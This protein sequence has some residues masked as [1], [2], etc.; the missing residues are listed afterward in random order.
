LTFSE[1]CKLFFIGEGA[2]KLF[3][4]LHL[5]KTMNKLNLSLFLSFA[6]I[7]IYLNGQ[8][9]LQVNPICGVRIL[10]RNLPEVGLGGKIKWITAPVV[11]IEIR[12]KERPLS[13]SFQKDWYLDISPYSSPEATLAFNYSLVQYWTENNFLVNYDFGK[14]WQVNLGY[15]DMFRENNL[16]LFSKLYTRKWSGILYGL[17]KKTDWFSIGLRSKV[18]LN[19]D[20]AFLVGD[21]LYSL[22]MTTNFKSNYA[23][24]LNKQFAFEKNIV[25]KATAGTRIFHP[26]GDTLLVNEA[27]PKVGFMPTFGLEFYV[28]KLHLSFNIEKDFW[29]NVN[30]GSPIREVKGF[31]SGNFL[32]LRYHHKLKNERYLRLGAGYSFIRDLE[33]YRYITAQSERKFS[34]YQLKGIGIS[35]SYQVFE[36]A[37]IEI[38]HTLPLARLN[39]PFFNPKRLSL[40]VIWRL[41][42]HEK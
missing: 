11:G 13:I 37:D 36:N 2:R 40:G 29:L 10:S 30:G 38:K 42:R 28:E 18:V 22:T 6:I 27:Y 14:G 41:Y 9:P 26:K 19:P 8:N 4:A 31:V 35:A 12:K 16:T 34:R 17:T 33:Q 25:V 15:Y 3:L 5:I 23:N 32:S 7:S 21:A 20:F 1:L 24:K 39:E